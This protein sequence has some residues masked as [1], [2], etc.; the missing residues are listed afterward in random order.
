MEQKAN[1]KKKSN[2]AEV[3]PQKLHIEMLMHFILMVE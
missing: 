3:H 2:D 1:A